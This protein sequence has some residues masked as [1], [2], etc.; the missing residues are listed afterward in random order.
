MIQ[1]KCKEE[2]IIVTFPTTERSLNGAVNNNYMKKIIFCFCL[3]MSASL[4]FAQKTIYDANAILREGKGYTAIE[5]SDGID[6][7]IS[8]GDE[9]IA[10][11]ASEDKYRDKI[12]TVVENGVLKIS[13]DEKGFSWNT[14][15]NLKAYVSFK[16]LAALSASG[17]SDIVVEG[18]IKTDNLDIDISGGCDFKGRVEV[19]KLT[20]DQS[21]GSDVDISGKAT[22]V[23]INASGGSDFNGYSLVTDFCDAEASGGSDIEITANKEI[24]AK[25][26]G[27]SDISYKGSASLIGTKSSGASN[28]SKKS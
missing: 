13:Y 22:K 18:S 17:G 11:S 4:L 8:Y 6:L 14:K 10:V 2:F 28:V 24:N 1:C 3:L 9:A 7:F 16:K 5:V 25:A 26:T 19:N 15:R 23:I 21:G 20:V 12:K 27:A